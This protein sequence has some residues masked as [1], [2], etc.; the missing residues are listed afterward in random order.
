M[1]ILNKQVTVTGA[2]VIKDGDEEKR[3]AF[4]NASVPLDGNPSIGHVIED[5]DEFVKNKDE[6]LNDFA[7]FDEYVYGLDVMNTEL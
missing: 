2:S 6:V 5:K 3:I 7:A 1:V 4:M